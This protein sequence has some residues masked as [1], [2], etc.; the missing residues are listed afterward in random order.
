VDVAL[1]ALLRLR[2]SAHAAA[3]L[4]PTAPPAARRG[5]T[6]ERATL[7]VGAGRGAGGNLDGCGRQ[8]MI[9]ATGISITALS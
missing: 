8:L 3:A 6:V 4:T 2:C 9:G 7:C 5:P 1:G